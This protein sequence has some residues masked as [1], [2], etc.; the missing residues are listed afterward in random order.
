MYCTS[1]YIK[2]SLITSPNS[3]MFHYN[4]GWD[5]NAATFTGSKKNIH[6]RYRNQINKHGQKMQ[7]LITIKPLL[8]HHEIWVLCWWKD[9]S[10]Y[11]SLLHSSFPPHERIPPPDQWW[12]HWEG[13]LVQRLQ[14]SCRTVWDDITVCYLWC[15]LHSNLITHKNFNYAQKWL[16]CYFS[17]YYTA[18]S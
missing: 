6:W 16:T 3:V 7:P 2:V 17:M 10:L 12:R 18:S 1:H 14:P 5:W 13:Q 8:H 11:T 9:H 4:G 15:T